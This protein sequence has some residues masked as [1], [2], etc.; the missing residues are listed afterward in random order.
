M[1]ESI[2]IKIFDY[3]DNNL[4]SRHIIRNLSGKFS[5]TI[6]HDATYKICTQNV[7]SSLFRE[8]V[9]FMKIKIENDAQDE[10]KVENLIKKEDI[11]P[12]TEKIEK[13]IRKSEKII[14]YQATDFFDEDTIF[15]LQKEYTGSFII[16]TVFQILIVIIIG[17]YHIF[18][19]RK[20][21]ISNKVINK[22][23]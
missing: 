10:V 2:Q 8:K 12:F 6:D 13:I 15:H 17:V 14:K 3:A 20:F 16:F 22:C 19:F 1:I 23:P 4:I 21:L 18:S 9:V 7:V 5:F 11:N